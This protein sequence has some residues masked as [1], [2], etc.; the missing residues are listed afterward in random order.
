M[1]RRGAGRH[2]LFAR[3]LGLLGE[4][5]ATAP[6]VPVLEDLHWNDESSP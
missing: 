2:R 4:L 6:L 1:S 3:V 5:A